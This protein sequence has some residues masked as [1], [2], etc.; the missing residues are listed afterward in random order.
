MII[1]Y[2]RQGGSGASAISTYVQSNV[3]QSSTVDSVTYLSTI[4]GAA[5]ATVTVKVTSLSHSYS[6][7][8]FTV[9]GISQALNSTFTVTL[10]SSGIGTFTQVANV[11]TTA[12]GNA[13]DV[14][15]TLE[16]TTDGTIQTPNTTN[17]SWTT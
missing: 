6:G 3:E 7:Y 11:G 10:N 5:L 9:N 2:N 4:K 16:S 13:I 15:C 14:I 12:P 17:V 8:S 1:R